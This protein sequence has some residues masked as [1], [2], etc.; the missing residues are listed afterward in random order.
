MRNQSVFAR[1]T[2]LK[3]PQGIEAKTPLLV[4]SFSSKGFQKR[5]GKSEI[6]DIYDIASEYLSECM[7]VSAFDI[8]NGYIK[9]IDGPIADII[10]VD[11]GGYEISNSY[12]LSTLNYESGYNEQWTEENLRG[13]YRNLKDQLGFVLVNYDNHEKR[14]KL[15]Q[16][17]EDARKLFSEFPNQLHTILIKPE[18]KYQNYIQCKDIIAN[19]DLLRGFDIV[20]F[21]EKEVGRSI[22]ER[23]DN[24]SKIRLALDDDNNTAPMHI[25]G[26]LDPM[27]S[28]MYFC[29][30][31]EIF[32]GLTWLRYGYMNGTA[33]YYGNFGAISRDISLPD[34]MMKIYMISDNISYLGRMK[35]QMLKY[36]IDGDFKMF[37]EN[38]EIIRNSF[39]LLK[40]RNRRVN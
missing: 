6:S 8:H 4:P 30:G 14:I 29:A 2:M 37:G 38:S 40:T 31:A 17:V 11:S 12:D 23:M 33:C 34:D 7:L 32:D 26:S 13:V 27:T 3:H 1:S 10:I 18:T 25:Y 39:N 20:G 5:N 19:I 35:N 22:L 21:T 9:N 24:I 28:I 16:Q 36:L 15:D